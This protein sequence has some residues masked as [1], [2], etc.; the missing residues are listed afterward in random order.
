M[1]GGFRKARTKFSNR[2]VDF[3]VIRCRNWIFS[4]GKTS[5]LI[6]QSAAL[7][8]FRNTLPAGI[9]TASSVCP[10]ANE[11]ARVWLIPAPGP[12]IITRRLHHSFYSNRFLKRSRG[13]GASGPYNFLS[14]LSPSLA[15]RILFVSLA[16]ESLTR[17]HT[18]PVIGVASQA[19]PRLHIRTC[20]SLK[21]INAGGVVLSPWA[22]I[23][24]SI[25]LSPYLSPTRATNA[26]SIY[27]HT[28]KANNAGS[29][30]NDLHPWF[31]NVES[32]AMLCHSLCKWMQ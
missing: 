12:E 14:A 4:P 17:E 15:P 8:S 24:R 19:L 2:V 11:A 22:W 9:G 20:T 7:V 3:R 25:V 10:L 28:L 30:T 18:H 23:G 1:K 16:I 6:I 5:F 29:S 32:S 31:F 13:V 21:L 27:I 26:N